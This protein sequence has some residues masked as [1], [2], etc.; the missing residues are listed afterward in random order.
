MRP[1][2]QRGD[3]IE[4]VGEDRQRHIREKPGQRE[5]R[6]TRIHENGFIRLDPA[7]REPGDRLFLFPPD[8]LPLGQSECAAASSANSAPS[9]IRSLIS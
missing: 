6:R 2:R 8:R 1:V 5:N 7:G 9:S 3:H 4:R